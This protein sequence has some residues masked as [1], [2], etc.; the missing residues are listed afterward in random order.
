[1]ANGNEKH[2][3]TR[4]DTRCERG[5]EANTTNA[6]PEQREVHT[7]GWR[8][9]MS[10]APLQW[11][12]PSE[13]QKSNILWHTWRPAVGHVTIHLWNGLRVLPS[14]KRK[15][16]EEPKEEK[17]CPTGEIDEQRR[18]TTVRKTEQTRLREALARILKYQHVAQNILENNWERKRFQWKEEC[19]IALTLFAKTSAIATVINHPN[20]IIAQWI[21]KVPWRELHW[22]C[23]LVRSARVTTLITPSW[24][25]LLG[26]RPDYGRN[27]LPQ[28][29]IFNLEVAFGWHEET[30]SQPSATD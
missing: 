28:G 6:T 11:M 25:D 24:H 10:E 3:A 27:D 30:V 9:W 14:R 19:N 12:K 22:A 8:K 13:V 1:M 20:P 23:N 5:R 17:E 18:D 7:T 2:K 16:K 15:R 4:K 29:F 21:Q 26:T